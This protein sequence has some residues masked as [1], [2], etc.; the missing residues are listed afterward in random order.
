MHNPTAHPFIHF[1]HNLA[2][3]LLPGHSDIT[4]KSIRVDSLEF[5]Y[6]IHACPGRF[7]AM[8]VVKATIVAILRRYDLRL[9]SS[10]KVPR[11]QYNRLLVLIPPKAQAV[12]FRRRGKN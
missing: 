9:P 10:E 12:E 8:N 7:F 1:S 2:F 5:G 3:S 4:N 11:P 6:G